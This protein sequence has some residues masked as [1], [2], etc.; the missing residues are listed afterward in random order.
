MTEI[1][2]NRWDQLIRRVANIVGGGSQVNDTLNELF[3]V[4][5]VENMPAE[6]LYLAGTKIAMGSQRDLASVGDLHLHQLFNP[7]DS[8]HILTLT[9]VI[10]S[11]GVAQRIRWALQST[12]VSS[13]STNQAIRDSRVSVIERAIGSI[14][15]VTQVGGIP[16]FGEVEIGVEIPFQL[17]VGNAVAVLLPG[18]GFTIATTTANNELISS[19]FWRERLAQPAELNF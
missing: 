9:D 4:L 13:S 14:R 12:A 6:L 7:I 3:P 2:Q 5:D 8:G 15:G 10:F 19:W 1:Q 11:S 16:A 18:T 17:S